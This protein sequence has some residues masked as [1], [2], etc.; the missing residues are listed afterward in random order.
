M[1]LYVNAISSTLEDFT[2]FR[3]APFLQPHNYQ[4][5]ETIIEI[6]KGNTIND[7]PIL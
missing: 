7:N 1:A 5:L 4:I 2:K 6:K 3:I